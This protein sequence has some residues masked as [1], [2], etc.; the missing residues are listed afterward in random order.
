MTR[1]L[2]NA[3]VD[4][5]DRALAAISKPLGEIYHQIDKKISQAIEKDAVRPVQLSWL[6][7]DT[8]RKSI[9]RPIADYKL[10]GTYTNFKRTSA[11]GV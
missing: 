1:K 4:R 7:T 6:P 9:F 2:T 8:A 3:E 10:E 5:H 11:W